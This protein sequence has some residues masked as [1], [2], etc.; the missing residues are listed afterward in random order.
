MEWPTR[1]A[2]TSEKSPPISIQPSEGDGSNMGSWPPSDSLLTKMTSC[3]SACDGIDGA[4]IPLLR[5]AHSS[6]TIEFTP[7]N[8]RRLPNERNHVPSPHAQRNLRAQV[9]PRS[10]PRVMLSPTPMHPRSTGQPPAFPPHHPLSTGC[11]GWC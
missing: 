4:L 6:P 2:V 10:P 11:A 8:S 1:M 5:S 7:P 3:G 9:R